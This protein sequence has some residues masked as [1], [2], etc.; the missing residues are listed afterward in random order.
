[1]RQYC[2]MLLAMLIAAC[3]GNVTQDTS[4]GIPEKC[5][6]DWVQNTFIRMDPSS[7]ALVPAA[8]DECIKFMNASSDP[9]HNICRVGGEDDYRTIIILAC[10]PD[11]VLGTTA[12][13]WIAT[14][15]FQCENLFGE[16][17]D[18]T[19]LTAYLASEAALGEQFEQCIVFFVD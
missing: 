9:A 19:L 5:I 11:P 8:R 16:G 1:M 7:E 6:E 12:K 14:A 4:G 15:H 10:G 2:T 17:G 13:P 3:G 18:T